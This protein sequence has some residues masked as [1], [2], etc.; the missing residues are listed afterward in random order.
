M[1]DVN[2]KRHKICVVGAGHVGLVAAACFAEL[3]HDVICVDS[4]QQRVESLKKFILPFY[5]PELDVLVEKNIKRNSIIFSSGF[6]EGI[7]NSQ[8][9]FIINLIKT[10]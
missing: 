10:Y 3:G 8:V 6:D 4:D 5:E 2:F 1:Q 7:K 9:I